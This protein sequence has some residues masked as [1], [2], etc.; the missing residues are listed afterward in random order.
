MRRA[1]LA[2]LGG[3]A[4]LAVSALAV[5][6]SPGRAAVAN[7]ATTGTSSSSATPSYLPVGTPIEGADNPAGGPLL[8]APGLYLDS[9]ERGSTSAG[10]PGSSKYYAVEL[11]KGETPWFSATMIVPPGYSNADTGELDL[12]VWELQGENLGCEWS[13]YDYQS[14]TGHTVTPFSISLHTPTVGGP[15]WP[16]DCPRN[17]GTFVVNVFRSGSLFPNSAMPLEIGF[18]IEP[19]AHS[20][21]LPRPAPEGSQL[22]A[23]RNGQDAKP[24]T[25]GYS[26]DNAPQ[27]GTGAYSDSI[28]TGQTRYVRVHLGWGQRFTYLIASSPVR[29][30]DAFSLTAQTTIFDPMRG[31]PL[32]QASDSD[33]ETGFGSEGAQ[34]LSGTTLAPVR[35]TNRTSTDTHVQP[36]AIAGDYFLAITL[37]Y[38][39]ADKRTAIPYT[40]VVS[41]SGRVEPGPSYAATALPPQPSGSASAVAGPTDT[42]GI[43]AWALAGIAAVVALA[44][45]LIG[46]VLR[47]GG[48]H[49]GPR[50]SGGLTTTVGPV[51]THGAMPPEIPPNT[52]WPPSAVPPPGLGPP[53]P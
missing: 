27:I 41:V 24:F 47:R 3:L 22:P 19:P 14:T 35:Y 13:A 28:V 21:D 25:A 34:H 45:L 5:T 52:T 44:L 8:S 10:T 43:S 18:H 11:H 4:C 42:G 9:L 12:K 26:F 39:N 23:Q 6:V 37:G 32:D 49:S 17:G 31:G 40:L 36:Y 29:G 20:A 48:A 1:A 7:G 2:A 51:R 50:H 46:L 15:N 30:I 53:P 33:Y 16:S 38:N